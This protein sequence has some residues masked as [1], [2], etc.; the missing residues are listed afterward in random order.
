MGEGRTHAQFEATVITSAL[1]HPVSISL[2]DFHDE[3]EEC[4]GE[5]SPD[6]TDVETDV[7]IYND[8][9]I[10]VSVGHS[11]PYFYN[12]RFSLEM[13]STDE[14]DM[15]WSSVSCHCCFFQ[16][17]SCVHIYRWATEGWGGCEKEIFAC[18]TWL[19]NVQIN[20][21]AS[22]EYSLPCLN[23]PY[24]HAGNPTQSSTLQKL[25]WIHHAIHR[26][27]LCTLRNVLN[28][29]ELLMSWNE[30]EFDA[31]ETVIEQLTYNALGIRHMCYVWISWNQN[32]SEAHEGY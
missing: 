1:K 24:I 15:I 12:D 8:A 4:D 14:H 23:C 30:N 31:N 11:L 26:N 6:V 13:P 16:V 20:F 29:P 9:T 18:L 17:P 22:I 19:D 3:G 27:T 10:C 28:I 7:A 25:G 2:D 21:C 32:D 5:T